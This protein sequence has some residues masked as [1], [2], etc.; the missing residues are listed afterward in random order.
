MSTNENIRITRSKSKQPKQE[1]PTPLPKAKRTRISSST[2]T[3]HS[4]YDT[5]EQRESKLENENKE[6]LPSEEKAMELQQT[7]ETNSVSDDFRSCLEQFHS[8]G[9]SLNASKC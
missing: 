2:Q 5:V 9:T 3:E 1:N 4:S 6:S 8:E 7:D